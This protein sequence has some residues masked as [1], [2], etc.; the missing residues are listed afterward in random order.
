MADLCGEGHRADVEYKRMSVAYLFW[1][2][3][4][5]FGGHRF[6]LGHTAT[7]FLYAFTGGLFLV[8]AA[9]PV[10]V[11]VAARAIDSMVR[12]LLEDPLPP[13]FSDS[14]VALRREV[15]V[16]ILTGEKV[17]MPNGFYPFLK[18]QAVDIAEQVCITRD[19]VQVEADLVENLGRFVQELGGG[20]GAGRSRH[21]AGETSTPG[22]VCRQ[23]MP[24]PPGYRFG[25]CPRMRSWKLP[26][27]HTRYTWHQVISTPRTVVICRRNY[28]FLA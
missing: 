3:L 21:D 6:Y 27:R 9:L 11:G 7:G 22:R 8:G 18:E 2:L 4:G 10:A 24:R 15:R 14:W 19:N 5:P 16:P 23:F 20:D 26:V 25:W 13:P 1:L 28:H 12:H 17:E